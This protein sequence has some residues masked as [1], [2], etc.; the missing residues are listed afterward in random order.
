MLDPDHFKIINDFYGQVFGDEC[1]KRVAETLLAT[2]RRET[3]RFALYG[4]EQIVVLSHDTNQQDSEA[5]A[6]KAL[7]AIANISLSFES[8]RV[9]LTGSIAIATVYS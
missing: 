8:L 2:I 3:D 6:I 9:S 5:V 1:L 7:L 4:G